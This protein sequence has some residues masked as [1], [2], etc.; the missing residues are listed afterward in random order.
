M[1]LVFRQTVVAYQLREVGTVYASRN[2]MPR[3]DREEGARVIVKSDGV[4]E[5]GSL[6]HALAIPS[7]ALRT[8]VKPPCRAELQRRVVSGERRKLPA[9]GAFVEG[10]DNQRQSRV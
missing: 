4:V 2:V 6:R 9:V 1:R 8:V 10:E 5:T 7:H 3:R